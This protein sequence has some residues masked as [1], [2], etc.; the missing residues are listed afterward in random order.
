MVEALAACSVALGSIALG[1]VAVAGF[2]LARG[3][4]RSVR[5]G[6]CTWLGWLISGAGAN[7]F[8]PNAAAGVARPASNTIPAPAVMAALTKPSCRERRKA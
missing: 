1:S 7:E 4:V 2:A 3:V 8:Q 6:R 5:A